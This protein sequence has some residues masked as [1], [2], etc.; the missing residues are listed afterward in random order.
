V[1]RRE[2]LASL[3]AASVLPSARAGAQQKVKV[4]RLAG[5]VPTDPVSVLSET[6]PAPP[7]RAFFERLRQ[8]GFV[9]GQNLE[10]MRFSG[11]GHSERFD[12]MVKEVVNLKP[13]VIFVTSTRLLLLFKQAT[14]T[15]PIVSLMA[16]PVRVG[17]VASMARPGGNITGVA[18]DQGV[19]LFDKRFELLKEAVPRLSKLGLL[20]S[21]AWM[22]R[23]KVGEAARKLTIEFMSPFD[24]LYWREEDYR[25]AFERMVR[26]GVDGI[27]VPEQNENITYGRTIIAL[28][29]EFR[30]PAIYP[31]LIFVEWGGLM[32]Y[33]FVPVDLFRD[34][35]RIVVEIFNGANP[36]NIPISQPTKYEIGLNL[37]TAKELG[38]EIPASLL[39][40]ADK[41][42]E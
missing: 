15:I 38:I 36:A 39:V 19:D 23:I 10:V 35:A 28:A 17:L 41:V 20:I 25:F 16:D 11:E 13:D 21:R 32:S 42:I 33:G 6:G 1:K 8:L 40:Q 3:A 26:E 34:C 29:K 37:K 12:E 7:E 24:A 18:I 22:E 14:T 30:L 27:I 9:D 4:H 5:V 2:F 31:V